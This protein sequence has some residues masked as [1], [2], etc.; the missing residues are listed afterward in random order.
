[1]NWLNLQIISLITI[2]GELFSSNFAAHFELYVCWV[3][4]YF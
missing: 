1:M 2:Q 4:L 3:N